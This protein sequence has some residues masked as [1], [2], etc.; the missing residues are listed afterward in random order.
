M[1]VRLNKLAKPPEDYSPQYIKCVRSGNVT[2]FTELQFQP[3]EI[4]TIRISNDYYILASD[5]NNPDKCNAVTDA[6]V[7]YL[8]QDEIDEQFL[9]QY[10][11][12]ET[13]ADETCQQSVKRS[14]EKI[15]RII[16]ANCTD[17]A[18]L[19]WVTL[20]YAENMTDTEQLRA[21]FETF[22]K[23]FKR[24]CKKSGYPAPE[25]ITVVEPQGRGAWHCHCFFIWSIS[26]PYIDNNSTLAP[27]WGHGFVKITGCNS[28][29]DNVGA[30]F[31]AYLSDMSLD[32]F[33]NSDVA[34]N[35]TQSGGNFPIVTKSVTT[36]RQ[37]TPVPKTEKKFVKGARLVLYPPNMRIYRTSRGVKQPDVTVMTRKQAEEEKAQA[38]KLTFQSTVSV[39][40]IPEDGQ[41]LEQEKRPKPQIVHKEY[42]NKKRK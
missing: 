36:D 21:D 19:H 15:R 20:T 32:E 3:G 38:G 11:H 2:E 33:R 18:K 28:N 1:N 34:Q 12:S 16:N 40:K 9:H 31:S 10:E 35:V 4:G 37:G 42:Y 41:E 13:K 30:Y 7:R 6:I 26:C 14:L 5:Y 29:C 22:W 23:R 17:A 25:Y 39:E 24:W 27:M 8:T